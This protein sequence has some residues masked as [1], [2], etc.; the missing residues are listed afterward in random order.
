MTNSPYHA[1]YKLYNHIQNK[2]GSSFQP[3]DEKKDRDRRRLEQAY[4][5][6]SIY[7]TKGFIMAKR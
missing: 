6:T 3:A 4:K 7:D 5:I 2:T 1:S